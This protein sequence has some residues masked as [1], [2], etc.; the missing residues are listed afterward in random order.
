MQFGCPAGDGAATVSGNV[1]QLVFDVCPFDVNTV[2]GV[3]VGW[4][5]TCACVPPR[6]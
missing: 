6:P 2:S 1:R 5:A 3:G 4:H